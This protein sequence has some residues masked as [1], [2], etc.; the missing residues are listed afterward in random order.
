[1]ADATS[2]RDNDLEHA[3]PKILTGI[4][5]VF[6][7]QGNQTVARLLAEASISVVETS[8]DNW[9]GGTYGYTVQIH[10]SP[11]QFAA[12]GSAV[13]ELEKELA[14]RIAHFARA[15]PNESVEAV[16]LTPILEDGQSLVSHETMSWPE[17]HVRLFLSHAGDYR[18]ET[19]EL[20]ALLAEYGVSAFAAHAHIEATKEWENEIRSALASCVALACLLTN[21]FHR[22]EWTDHEVGFAIGLRK[23][24]VPIQLGCVPYGLMARYQG[25]QAKNASRSDVALAIVKILAVHDVTGL[26]M[27]SS[28]VKSFEESE[29][30]AIA[31]SRVSNLELISVWSDDLTRRVEEA[32]I[33]NSQISGAYGIPQR[34]RRLLGRH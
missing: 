10:T 2:R 34:V 7:E 22:S 30:Y 16:I 5:A 23:L 28:L 4:R 6:A 26:K 18:S 31:R 8:F 32:V 17:G 11:R 3:I 15:Y 9:N 33:N 12:L 27:A 14:N 24:V 1:M 25:H 20:A 19:A 21:D 29:S 13:G